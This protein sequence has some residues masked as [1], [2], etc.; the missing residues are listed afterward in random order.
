MSYREQSAM[1]N[2]RFRSVV[3]LI[4]IE[5]RVYIKSN[6]SHAIDISHFD[7]LHGAIK[8]RFRPCTVDAPSKLARTIID[9][10]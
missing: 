4:R 10:L 8:A 5:L 7:N 2:R 6:Q 1:S 3:L 9:V